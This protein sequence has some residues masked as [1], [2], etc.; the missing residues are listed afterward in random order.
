MMPT[1]RPT[2]QMT[3]LTLRLPE[4]TFH[5]TIAVPGD[6]SLSHR[7]L[8]LAAMAQGASRVEGAGPG[9]DIASTRSVLQELGVTIDG[10]SVSSPGVQGWTEPARVLDCGNSGTT[11]RLMA[12]ALAGRPFGSVLTGDAS[13]RRRP[14]R[15]LVDP[16]AALGA[17]VVVTEPDGSPPVRIGAT[18]LLHGAVTSVG[19]ASAQVRSAFELA[20]LQA[21]GPSEIDSPP[22]YRDHTE[23]ML[24]AMGLG[25]PVTA[26]RFQILP[27]DVPAGEYSVPGD[28]SSAAFLWALAAARRGSEVT[29]PEI[30]LN[31]GRIGFL[32]ILEAFG[33]EIHAEVTGAL[34]G[35]PVGTVAVRGRGL[36]AVDVSGGLATAALDELPLVGVLGA[37][38]EG[39][40]VV[41]DAAELSAKESDRIASTVALIRSLGGGAEA[42][43]DGFAVVGTGFLEP[44]RVDSM[45]D[46]RI[47]M[48]AAV[49]AARVD[50]A[51]EIGDADCVAVS[52]PQ[53]FDVVEALWSSP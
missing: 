35:D 31:P 14:M 2:P 37:L 7:A 24:E 20:A 9:A 52:W 42:T 46:H 4:R 43:G 11:L 26:T 32:Q 47:A 16:L 27:G 40:T 33:A 34:Q 50:G 29:T 48:A 25:K 39:I 3:D 6:K 53:Y 28:P 10:E 1:A 21:E 41:R 45:G 23:R 38:A 8:I 5:A 18:P 17:E 19:L 13:L 36:F 15:R 22:G 49:A 51:V 12:G 30:S 44:G